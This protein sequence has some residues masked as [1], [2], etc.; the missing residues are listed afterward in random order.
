MLWLMLMRGSLCDSNLL[1]FR[2]D[3]MHYGKYASLYLKRIFYFDAN[4]PLGKMM[5][6]VAAYLAG[7]DGEFDFEKIG[8][9][10]TNDIP[11]WSLRFVPAFCGSLLSPLVYL[12][13]CELGLKQW[14]GFLA[15]LFIIFGKSLRSWQWNLVFTEPF[16]FQILPFLP[17]QGLFCWNPSC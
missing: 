6:A 4:P 3:E 12:I 10:Y 17:N 9:P 5:I 1:S 11:L 16:Y 2:F 14:P 13:L 7:F 8:T 15:G